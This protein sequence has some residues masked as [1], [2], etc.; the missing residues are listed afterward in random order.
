MLIYIF[1]YIVNVQ[2]WNGTK[3]WMGGNYNTNNSG[4]NKS[5]KWT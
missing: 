2:L 1:I 5:T 3:A 4:F